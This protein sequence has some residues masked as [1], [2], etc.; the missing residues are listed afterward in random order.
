M[1]Y[2][3]QPSLLCP[4][5]DHLD[6]LVQCL[7]VRFSMPIQYPLS[8]VPPWKLLHPIFNFHLTASSK[9][10]TCTWVFEQQFLEL[11]S[12]SS[13]HNI[14]RSSALAHILSFGMKILVHLLWDFWTC[15]CTR[16]WIVST[17]R[18]IYGTQNSKCDICLVPWSAYNQGYIKWKIF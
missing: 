16:K 13:G 4:V 15:G 3:D 6:A 2:E 18:K 12:S 1:T 10:H 17:C 14:Y 11:K 7:D 8:T 5:S 9:D